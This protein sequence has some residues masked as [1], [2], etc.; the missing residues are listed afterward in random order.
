MT[1]RAAVSDLIHPKRPVL[2]SK[3]HWYCHPGDSLTPSTLSL[4][5]YLAFRLFCQLFSFI[6]EVFICLKSIPP[7]LGCPYTMAPHG[8]RRRKHEGTC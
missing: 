1:H 3:C 6:C 2:I 4:G 5:N 8:G 7:K